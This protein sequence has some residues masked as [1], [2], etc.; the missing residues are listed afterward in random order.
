MSAMEDSSPSHTELAEETCY[1]FIIQT[2]ENI[3]SLE[4]TH[5]WTD[6]AMILTINPGSDKASK[7]IRVEEHFPVETAG[8]VI[9]DY[10]LPETIGEPKLL[11]VDLVSHRLEILKD[12][13]FIRQI[14]IMYKRHPYR[15]PIKNHLYPHNPMAGNPTH[16]EMGCPPHFLVREGAGTLK[17]QE[18]EE[19]I[20]KAREEDM[21]TIKSMVYW[22]QKSPSDLLYPGY[23]GTGDYS[24][25]PRFLKFRE[26]HVEAFE[27]AKIVLDDRI[28]GNAFDILIKKVFGKY[29]EAKMDSFEQYAEFV[30]HN[31]DQFGWIKETVEEALKVAKVFRTDEEFGRQAL[32]GV[33]SFQ[34]RKVTSLGE[35]WHDANVP[36]Y[37]LE[38]KS[39]QEVIEEGHLFEITGDDLIDI[40][41]GGSRSKSLM[42]TQHIWYVV[43]ADCLL[44]QRNDEKLV[45]VQIRLENRNDGEAATFW[46]PP[47]P[48]LT[49][50]NHPKNLAWLY[51]KMW[52]KC[53]DTNIQ[54]FCKHFA[55]G[56][57]TNEAFA[58]AIYRNLPN[59]HPMF[60]VLQPHIMGIIPIDVQARNVLINPGQNALS[61]FLSAGDYLMNMFSNHYKGFNYQD[62]I[63]PEE[64]KRRGVEDIPGYFFR[65]DIMSYWDILG[66]Y[67]RRMV[68][69]AYSSDEDVEKDEEMKNVLQ[70]LKENGFPGF[71]DNAGFPELI[72][73]KEKLIEFLTAIL[74]NFAAFHPSVNFQNFT[75]YGFS[76]NSPSCLTSPP[77]KV[78]DE[79]TM[80]TILHSL[81]AKEISYITMALSYTL[82]SYSPIERY[83]VDSVSE[84]RLGLI[85]E[86]MAVAPDQEDSIHLL[87][88][89]MRALKRKIDARNKELYIKYDILNPV[90]TPITPQ[91]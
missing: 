33:N 58:M 42:G 25:L 72:T 52:F 83:F 73:D 91:I 16:A 2:G 55:R 28:H 9:I 11:K 47:D 8:A 67:I 12:A 10:W 5:K 84:N 37:A 27:A 7:E 50:P 75:Y 53:A 17:H 23:F 89:D 26:A 57:A 69:L 14:T 59:A 45:P 46:A 20:I 87:T 56:H 31:S 88:A 36:E 24:K 51:A 70:D 81:P 22:D 71:P 62:L 76:P 3:P 77:P 54:I 68:D 6:G 80:E 61:T 19:Y 78:D 64:I 21:N 39:I 30:K 40:P 44:Y 74:V 34:M 35:R 1:T 32:C 43:L 48:E 79:I 29:R 15:F 49:D 41:H 86:H 66:R 13:L 65:D 82:G 90:N 63:L 4:G 85:G 60:R 38:G 18:T